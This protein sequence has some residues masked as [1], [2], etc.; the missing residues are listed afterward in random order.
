MKMVQVQQ[1]AKAMG[2][3]A[4][5]MSKKDLIRSIQEREGYAA[6]YQTGLA[7]CDQLDCCWRD[8]CMVRGNS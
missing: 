6:C 5:R 3:P 2:L 1:K 8:D 4:F 7:R